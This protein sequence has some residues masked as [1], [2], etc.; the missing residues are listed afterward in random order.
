[1]VYLAAQPADLRQLDVHV[2][3]EDELAEV[4]WLTL[5]EAEQLLPGMYAP[6]RAYLSRALRPRH[7][8]G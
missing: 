7:P 4:R 5:A 3:D 6:V 2:G 1:M 8:P